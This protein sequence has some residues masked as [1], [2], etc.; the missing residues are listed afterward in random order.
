MLKLP[1]YLPKSKLKAGAVIMLAALLFSW[2]SQASGL[3]ELYSLKTLDLF[4]RYVPLPPASREIVLVTVDQPD[5]DFFKNQGVTWPWPR[6][7]YV[8]IIEFCQRGGARAV[9]MDIFY[10]E[11]SSYGPEDD[12]RLA[13]A[14]A[15]AGNVI[16]AF[17]LSQNEREPNPVESELLGKAGLHIA[18]PPPGDL[19]HYRSVLSPIQPLVQAAQTLGNVGA[20]A[21][22][23][24]T[25]RRVPLVAPFQDLWLPTLAFAAFQR[26]HPDGPWRFEAGALVQGRLR[27]PLDDQGQLLLKFRG[28]SRSHRR[29]S[30]ANIIRSEYQCRQGQTPDY[31]PAEL[32][33]KWVIVGLTAPGLY[34]LKASPVGAVYSGAE[35]HA[36]L[37]DNLLKGDFLKTVPLWG[38]WVW[39]LALTGL[40]VAAVLYAPGLAVVLGTLVILTLANLGVAVLAFMGSWWLDPIL[41]DETLTVAFILAAAY[42]YATEGRQ[43]LAIRR[44]FAQYMSEKVIHHLMQHPEKLKLG[45]ERRRVTLF[46]SDLAGFTT[47]SERLDPE[48]VVSLLNDYLSQMTDIILEE[49][50]TVDK[51]E[52]DAIMAF[53]G[54]PLDQED[55]ACRA[56][57]A[58]LCQQGALQE[59][60]QDFAASG[61]PVLTNRIGLHTGDAIVG[62]LGSEKRFDYTVIG[63][64][65]N[66]ASRLEGLNKFYGTNILA[67]ETTVQ[68][69]AG[70]MEFRELDRVAVKGRETP[71]AVFQVLALPG[72]LTPAQAGA[73]EEFARG[74]E[75]YRE[76]RF[77]AAAAH[78]SRALEY[79]PEDHPSLVFL[80]RC[81]QYEINP[82]PPDWDAVFRPDQK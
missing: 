16:F 2:G 71:I 20:T 78:F 24:G 8:P 4:F 81:Q 11:A 72:A 27:L 53:W 47:L 73:R 39:T 61:L 42:S 63:D 41:P 70:A 23:D 25:Y 68:E 34:D 12:H 6:Q 31:A 57:R 13:Q 66:L 21:D 77:A 9:I 38:V 28:P 10:T 60:N 33:G 29:F 82:P 49:E 76:G 62:N 30:A 52:G 17:S 55:Q 22:R 79:W 58:A 65:V 40:M 36:T 35:I 59:L 32:A 26:H 75:L 43:K 48:A 69:C 14:A 51:Y 64:T 3:M 18:G 37:L 5:L 1:G 54:A 56:C 45:G 80:T 74:L 46:F 7:L 67:S 15:A 44:M 19:P 50:G